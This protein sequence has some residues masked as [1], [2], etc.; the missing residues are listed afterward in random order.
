M[1]SRGFGVLIVIA[2]W[3]ALYLP[4]LGLS[5]L[6]GEEGKRVLPAVQ[7]LDRGDYLVPH[8]GARPY[9]NKPPMVSWLVAASFRAFGVRNEWSARLP[10]AILV[11]IVAVV[12]V[13]VG[14]T[15]LGNTG[16]TIAA[17]VWLTTLEV[18][19]KG[20]SIETDAINASFFGLA[21]IS[22]LTFWQQKRSAWVTFTVPWIFLGLGFL[23]K[24]P[25]LLLFFYSI[26]IAVAWRTRRLRELLH[27]AHWVGV[28]IMLAMVAAWAVPFFVSVRSR[29]LGEVWWREVTAILFGEKGRVENWALNFPRGLA[30]L[31]PWILVMPFVRFAKIDN[32][33]ERET[34]RG[35]AW[36]SLLPF[37]GVLVLPGAA[38]RYV[39]P[40]SA[41]LCWIIG[42][43]VANNA[44]EWQLRIKDFR[45]PIPR[46]L[47]QLAVVIAIVGEIIVFPIR[48]IIDARGH[49]VLKP[50]AARVNAAMPADQSLCA[51]DLP[52]KPYL[53]YVRAPV[54]YFSTLEE[55]PA[56]ARFLLIQFQ[57]LAKMEANPRWQELQPRLLVRSDPFRRSDTIL[58]DVSPKEAN[59]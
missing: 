36:G 51:V 52:Y 24:G 1:S 2:L 50:I 22:W 12:F 46:P 39:L 56:D 47:V 41:A 31:L 16:A 37:V 14:R 53:F 34:A 59:R 45:V 54:A 9:L 28:A 11:L 57:D 44:F 3:A 6:R 33:L 26:L 40:L 13:R 49:K 4:V 23:A 43:A 21:L 42:M 55:L 15:N 29:H 20:R 19:A 17:V 18:I 10:S 25:G 32:L 35:L 30:F 27:P 58:F 48:T 38:P 5:E 8:L 7:M